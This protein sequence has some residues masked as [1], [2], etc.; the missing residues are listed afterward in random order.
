MWT[1]KNETRILYYLLNVDANFN[2]KGANGSENII[3]KI[4]WRFWSYAKLL[5]HIES[6]ESKIII[7]RCLFLYAGIVTEKPTMHIL[8]SNVLTLL[9]EKCSFSDSYCTVRASR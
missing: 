1:V 3:L 9:R 7:E 2:M 6:C 4:K 8:Y 5:C